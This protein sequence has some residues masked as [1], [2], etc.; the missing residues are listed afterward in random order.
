MGVKEG[1]VSGL[2][3]AQG[4]IFVQRAGNRDIFN[5]IALWDKLLFH[6]IFNFIHIKLSKS[7]L[8]W[9]F[10]QP[11]NLNFTCSVFCSLVQMDI[12]TCPMWTLAI[13]P[14]RFP[15]AR[16]TPVW[17][18]DWGQHARHECP[19]ERAVSKWQLTP[20]FLPGEFYGQRSP[21]GY[22]PQG[23]KE[24]DMTEWLTLSLQVP[25]GQPMQATGFIHYPGV[26]CL[27]PLHTSTPQRK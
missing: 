14:W 11:E 18:L 8:L 26:C 22:S 7:P 5:P 6:Q 16:C 20:V 3:G 27:Q 24:S 9:I 13:A 12:M 4:P 19:L 10:Q 2:S 17:S 15:K 1:T 21:A 25:L 23:H